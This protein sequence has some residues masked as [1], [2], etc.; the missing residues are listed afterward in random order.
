M[1]GSFNSTMILAYIRQSIS[2]L[3]TVFLSCNSF[4][5]QAQSSPQT[6]PSEQNETSEQAQTS[7][8]QTS[9]NEAQLQ[10][11]PH[12][13]PKLSKKLSELADKELAEGRLDEALDYYQQ[14]APYA[15][16]DAAL[17]ERIAALRS[18]LVRD[19]VEAAERDALAGH[20]DVATEELAKALLI[21]PGNTI[22]AQ[23]LNQ[24]KAMN[25]G[26]P[27]KVNRK[28]EGLP[29][30]KPLSKKQSLN[31]TGD[32]KTAYEQVGEL[33]GIKVAFDP[34]LS[35]KPVHLKVDDVDFDTALK[36]LSSQT[37]TFWRPLSSTLMFVAQDTVEKHRQYGP[38]A[39][40]TFVL[41]SSVTTDEMSEL[42]RA[43]REMTGTTRVELD[44]HSRAVTMRDTPER[45]NLAGELIRQAEG[46]RSEVLLE[47]EILEVDR[48]KALNLGITPPTSAQLIPLTSKDLNTLK[49]ST[50]LTNLLTNLSGILSAKGITPTT[51]L[52]P[53]GGGLSTFLL[54]IPASAANFS[55]ALSLVRSGRQVLLRAQNGKPASFFVGDRF[56]VALSLLSA[57]LGT[58][59]GVAAPSGTTFPETTFNV[60]K[61]PSALVAAPFTGGTLPDLAVANRTDNTITILKNQD[62]GN[63]IQLSTS[64]IT[65]PS[66]AVGPVAIA[67]GVFRNDST[68]FSTAQPEDLVVVN[69]TSNNISILLG[70]ADANG[71]PNGTFTEAMGS[72]IAV[73]KNPSSVVV[74]DFN[75]D[76]FLDIAVANQTDNSISLFRGN[77]DG[78]FTQFPGSPFA[79]TNTSA[80]SEKGPVA[81]VSANFQNKLISTNSNAPE[82][83]LA[84]VNQSS[85]NVSILLSSVDANQNVTFTEDSRPPIAVGNSPVAIATGDLNADGVPDL[86]IVNQADATVTI[87]LGSANLDA[88]FTQPSGSPLV[89]ASTP[90]GIVIANF[91]SGSVPDLAVTNE[92]VNTLGVFVGR[93]QGTFS[94]PI[95]LNAPTG[96]TALITST[97]SSSGLPDVALVAQDPTAS[98][99]VVAVIL[100]T[101]N[102][103]SQNGSGGPAQQPYPGAEYVDLGVKVKATPTVHGNDEVTLQLEFEIR[104]LSGSSINGIPII[105]NRTISQTVRVKA[106]EPTL[107]GGLLDNEETK[108]LTGLPG[109][110]NLPIVGYAFGQRNTTAQDTEMI[111]LITPHKLRLGDRVSRSL[112][113]GHDSAGGRGSTPVP[114]PSQ[115][116][117]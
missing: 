87:L 67:S 113:V 116:Q 29:E 33:F 102:F 37:G 50:D 23:R 100:D 76:S 96:P 42:V 41:P 16:R 59:S 8:P 66:T 35:P 106:E 84:V 17:I 4:Y 111:I 117:P 49:S 92:G 15:P 32:T 22:V 5:A 12:P 85:S 90:S 83:D 34:D 79:L 109:F 39:E 107:I 56:P 82:V 20:A 60:G 7:P 46:A 10:M 14:A 13:N 40:Q 61:N 103:S 110:A 31:L 44:A 101:S 91:A 6:Q 1:D 58:S 65:L 71:V 95:E 75:G 68:K 27:L 38:Q 108:T 93:G 112:Y 36:I 98:N 86:A 88:T 18:K 64:P 3:L 52:L 54:S 9:P 105:T 115:R 72:P 53:I 25:D 57:S 74:A 30:L 21:D 2:L 26:P 48:N 43:L 19:H 24:M 47:I 80:I 62:S 63:F 11:A 97:L 45:L 51:S 69:S 94:S 78:T 77:G 55:D 70:N 104:A 89:T 73:G 99:G 114:L 28:I 81:M